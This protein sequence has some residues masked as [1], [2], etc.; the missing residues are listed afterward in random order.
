MEP[1]GEKRGKE[2]CLDMAKLPRTY[3]ECRTDCT[4]MTIAVK[5]YFNAPDYSCRDGN[6]AKANS[7]L[8]L[9]RDPVRPCLEARPALGLTFRIEISL[10][11]LDTKMNASNLV[12]LTAWMLGSASVLYQRNWLVGWNTVAGLDAP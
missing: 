8:V 3:V 2:L 11:K 4:I 6:L 5:V 10:F 9:A 1:V 12:G 7:L